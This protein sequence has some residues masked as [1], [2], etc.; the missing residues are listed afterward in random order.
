ME[1]DSGAPEIC[2]D[3]VRPQLPDTSTAIETAAAKS[4]DRTLSASL[5]N[6]SSGY[7]VRKAR[8]DGP[9][10]FDD[11][12]CDVRPRTSDR[13]TTKAASKPKEEGLSST[14]KIVPSEDDR[15]RDADAKPRS[16]QAYREKFDRKDMLS[17][18]QALPHQ[19]VSSRS[20]GDSGYLSSQ[21]ITEK[22]GAHRIGP[23]GAFG[24]SARDNS[25]LGMSSGHLDDSMPQPEIVHATAEVVDETELAGQIRKELAQKTLWLSVQRGGSITLVLSLFLPQLPLPLLWAWYMELPIRLQALLNPLVAT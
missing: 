3:D 12:E 13:S 2:Y 6:E 15:K 16:R 10:V 11:N 14:G 25:F 7:Q 20:M 1:K 9:E 4:K 19:E 23:V 18:K 17:N 22:P 24:D 8:G 5:K 21:E